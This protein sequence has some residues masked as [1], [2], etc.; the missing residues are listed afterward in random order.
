MQQGNAGRAE[1]SGDDVSE[2]NRVQHPPRQC[3]SLRPLPSAWFILARCMD[4]R[5]A[6]W[7]VS[8]IDLNRRQ[9][10]KIVGLFLDPTSSH[11]LV[12]CVRLWCNALGLACGLACA[13]CAPPPTC[14]EGGACPLCASLFEALWGDAYSSCPPAQRLI[15]LG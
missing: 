14:D 13:F 10:D 3:G 1:G 12:W 8:D 6:P 4:M 2:G 9:E 15:L 5:D 11:T 7:F